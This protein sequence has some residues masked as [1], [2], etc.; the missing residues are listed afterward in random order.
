MPEN[1]FQQKTETQNKKILV[2]GGPGFIG[3]HLVEA[4][5][6]R[7]DFVVC[8]DNFNDFYHPGQKELNVAPFLNNPNFKLFKININNID[9]LRVVFTENNIQ[10]IVHIAAQ[11]GVRGSLIDPHL[12]FNSNITGTLNLLDL[13]KEFGIKHFIF[14][15]SSS[16]YGKNNKVPFSENDNVDFPMSPYAAT[17]KAGELLCHTYYHL[18]DIN[19]TCLRFFCVYGPKGRPDNVPYKFTKVIESGE[20]L[21]M[22]GDGT[23]KRDYTYIDDII[24]GVL[25]AVDKPLGFEIINLGNSKTVDLKYFISVV[26][27]LLGKKA[28]IKQMP[29][30]VSD[31]HTTFADISKAKQLLGFSPKTNIEE[32]MARF[33]NWYKN[34]R[35]Q[36]K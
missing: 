35:F 5:L 33:V 9:A 16:I 30:P 29:Y 24:A 7:G 25:A 28:K 1:Q 17:K 6:K 22:F 21:P 2:T 26:E 32:G 10:K 12:Y 4:L 27:N 14:A 15:S 13:A 18:Y 23:A 8:V 20:E 11:A 31:V 36:E 19:T 3:S 34:E